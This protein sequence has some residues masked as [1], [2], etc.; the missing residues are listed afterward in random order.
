M[1]IREINVENFGP[2]GKQKFQLCKDKPNVILGHN[3]MGKTQLL[4]SLYAAFFDEGVLCYHQDSK[5]AGKTFI[6]VQ[7]INGSVNITQY[8][9]NLTSNLCFNK[10]EDVKKA[11]N[12][13]RKQLYFY[14]PSLDRNHRIQYTRREIQEAQQFLWSLGIKGHHILGTCLAKVETNVVMSYG[15][16]EY[17][18]LI[19][20]L[21]KLSDNAVFIGDSIFAGMDMTMTSMILEVLEHIRNVQII[22]AE[23][24]YLERLIKQ[25]RFNVIYLNAHTQDI[26]PVSYNYH[27]IIQN[28]N[29]ID[30][31]YRRDSV[32]DTILPIIYCIGDY[33]PN[34]EKYEI[35]LK[36][37]KG[38]NPCNSIIDNSEIYV[39]AYL[40]GSLREIGK[41][42]FGISNDRRIA[43]VKLSYEDIDEIQR[44]LSERLSQADP[45]INPDMYSISFNKVATKSGDILSDVY[46]IEVDVFPH[47]A[48]WLYST[49]KGDVYVKTVGGKRKLSSRQIQE[50]IIRRRIPSDLK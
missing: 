36:E 5:I 46:I 18:K 39:T 10:F 30:N 43:G 20:F 48:N 6:K 38:N 49:S 40:N 24:T 8:H 25:P 44:K 21:S 27:A 32:E 31:T 2:I 37:I 41:I 23:N 13:D 4:A 28:H 29:T 7:T 15:E 47:Y 12:I 33:L 16:R 19:C 45:F 3:A 26:S 17:I 1:Y 9:N 34:G 22:L 42:Y 14:I 35:E 11:A 50:E